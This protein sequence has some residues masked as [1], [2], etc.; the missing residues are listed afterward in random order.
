MIARK[1]NVYRLYPTPDQAATLA[2]W[3][4]AVR[5]AYNVALEQRRDW[6]RP[7]RTFNFATQCREV[8]ALRAEFDWLRVVPIHPLQ[9]AMK[10]LDRAYQNWWAGRASAPTPRKRGLNDAMRFPDPAGFD[11]RRLSRHWG[12]VK[13]PKLGWVR[14]RWDRGI[15][16]TVKNIT[17]SRRADQWTVAAQYEIEAPEPAPSALP[18]VGIDRGVAVFAALSDGTMIAPLN[19]GKKAQR[20]LA[21]A[22][23][24]LARKKKGSNNRKKQVR[25]VAR[26]NARIMRTRKDFLHK[27]STTIAKNHGAVVLEKLEVQNMVRSAAGTVEKPGRKVRQKAGLNRSIL[28]QGWG[29]F[30]MLLAYKLADHGGQ[31]IEVPAA[32]TSQTCAACGCVDTANRASQSRFACT[33]CGHEDNADRNAA[34]N[35]LNRARDTRLLP[36]EVARQRAH[37]AGTNRKAA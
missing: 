37:E 23:R 31:L 21:R 16:G 27:L 15:P 5:A 11:F 34:V 10:D 2:K 17:V 20:A 6:Y 26:L 36:V 3:V 12:E 22:Q 13:L 35:I 24:K 7:G 33:G 14:L 25:R 8:T 1:A 32:Y 19:A 28:D 29:L 4:G 9:Q 18:A 30:R